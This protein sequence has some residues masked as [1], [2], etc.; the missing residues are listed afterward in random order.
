VMFGNVLIAAGF[1]VGLDLIAW[2]LGK[3]TML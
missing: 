3:T 1:L 2:S